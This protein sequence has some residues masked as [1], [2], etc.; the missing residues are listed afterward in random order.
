[1]HRLALGMPAG[2]T[3]SVVHIESLTLEMMPEHVQTSR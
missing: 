2:D 3:F 1:V